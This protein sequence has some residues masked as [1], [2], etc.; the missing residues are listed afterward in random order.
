MARPVTISNE[1]ILTAAREVFLEGGISARTSEIARRAGV[2]EGTL[3]KRYPT[4]HALF[5]AAMGADTVAWTAELSE[6]VGRGDVRENLV[7]LSIDIIRELRRTVPAA[8]CAWGARTV[9]ARGDANDELIA[10]ASF[11]EAEM[12]LGRLRATD[13]LPLSRAFFAA[14]LGHALLE[15]TH[16]AQALPL[17]DRNFARTLVDGFLVGLKPKVAVEDPDVPRLAAVG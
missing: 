8:L 12:K 17:S 14:M 9:D 16:A 13:P 3:F 7:N 11:L 1:R 2:S 5:A 6:R 15:L 4:K 10:L